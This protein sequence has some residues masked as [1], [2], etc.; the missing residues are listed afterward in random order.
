M[1][2]YHRNHWPSITEIDTPSFFKH[3]DTSNQREV[4][5]NRIIEE[6]SILKGEVKQLINSSAGRDIQSSYEEAIY[7]V[8]V[9]KS[10]IEDKGGFK[11]F[12]MQENQNEAMF[13]LL[14][15]FV[16]EGS[17]WDINAEVN[18]G[19]GPVDF[20]VSRGSKDK[21]VI[22]FKLAKSTKLKQNLQHQVEV[23]KK[24]NDTDKAVIAILYFSQMEYLHLTTV[25]RELNLDSAENIILID[26]QQKLSA[27]NIKKTA[28]PY[29]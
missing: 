12:K 6:L 5:T 7:R 19:R 28:I 29:R 4:E 27:S 3:G 22:E 20:T 2:Q 17:A 24:A 8:K 15:Q 23:Y 25:L 18:N 14:F 10:V 9:L 16:K 26:A 11:V 1:A 13:Q 21:T